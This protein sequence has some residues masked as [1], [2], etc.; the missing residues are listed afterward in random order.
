MTTEKRLFQRFK[1]EAKII[2]KIDS[3][4]EQTFHVEAIDIG[5]GGAKITAREIL[6]DGTAVQ[7]EISHHEH[8][9]IVVLDGKVQ[10]VKKADHPEG[11]LRYT[12]GVQ[13]DQPQLLNLGQFILLRNVAN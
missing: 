5:G 8:D 1:K 9:D 11:D 6:A 3:D 2:C 13:F 12:M 10:W 7:L 4:P